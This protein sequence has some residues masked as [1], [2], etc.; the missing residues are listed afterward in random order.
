MSAETGTEG[1]QNTRRSE[2]AMQFHGTM[3]EMLTGGLDEPVGEVEGGGG[4]EHGNWAS[5][6]D[7]YVGMSMGAGSVNHVSCSLLQFVHRI[8]RGSVP[9]ARGFLRRRLRTR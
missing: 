5:D 7:V 3:R 6:D 4:R 1:S 2:E 8:L 9:W